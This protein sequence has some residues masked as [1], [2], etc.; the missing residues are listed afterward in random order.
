MST[1]NATMGSDASLE[2]NSDIF[3]LISVI[4]IISIAA[5]CYW[6]FGH[7]LQPRPRIVPFE[8]PPTRE[9]F[10]IAQENCDYDNPEQ[11]EE[12]KRHL[13]R[14]AMGTVPIIIAL[15]TEGSSIERLYKQGMLTDDM[16][17][18]VKERKQFVEQEIQDV[19]LEANSIR[20][21]WGEVIWAHAFHFHHMSVQHAAE[22]Q[23]EAKQAKDDKKQAALDKRKEKLKKQKELAAARKKKETQ[24]REAQMKL[25]AA[26]RIA[27]ELIEEEQ[28]EKASKLKKK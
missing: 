23:D 16:H 24:E 28:R 5:F 18:W 25:E 6:K 22:K 3:I 14:R 8:L 9:E 17:Y 15:Q 13:M 12:L 11:V 4:L 10:F 21:G 19:Q 26:E 27:R 2:H 7:I 1:E 20:E